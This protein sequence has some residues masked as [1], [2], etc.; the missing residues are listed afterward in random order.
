MTSKNSTI[1]GIFSITDILF[2]YLSH[3]LDQIVIPNEEMDIKIAHDFKGG[4]C[5]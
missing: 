5:L 1:F 3:I 4:K 2:S